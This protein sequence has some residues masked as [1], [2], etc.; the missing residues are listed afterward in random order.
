MAYLVFARKY[1]PLSFD[2]VVGQKHVTDTLRRAIERDRVAHAYIFTGTRG[3]GKT[4]TA[5]ILARALN[6]EKGPTP[7]PCGECDSCRQIIAG[8]NF[9]V[10]EIDGASNNSVE[11]VRELRDNIGYTSMT[12]RYRVFVIDE[13]HMLSKSAFNALLK[14][15]E[16]PPPRVVFILATTE[17]HKIPATIHSRC[18]RH[19]FRRI[20][21]EQI[22][23]RLEFIC[24][25]EGV[26]FDPDGLAIVARKADGSM[27]DGLSL[28]DQVYS[29]CEGRME[30]EQVRTVLGVVGS[31]SY[32]R[33]LQAVL[34]RQVEPVLDVVRDTLARGYD[35]HEFVVGLE[36]YLR[37]LI[38]ALI[39]GSAGAAAGHE[40]A[41]LREMAG[42]F[43]EHSL[44]RMAEAVRR[45][46]YEVSQ[47]AF[48][49][50][51]V[52]TLLLKLVYM[53]DTVSL[54]R[55]LG[56]VGGGALPTPAG[57]PKKKDL[58]AERVPTPAPA[59]PP[60]E[61]PEDRDPATFEDSPAGPA[62][63]LRA[64][65]KTFLEEFHAERPSLSAFLAHAQ[66]AAYTGSSLDLRFA[67]GFRFPFD[68]LVR[69]ANRALIE[70]RMAQFA[71]A[72]V[73]L[74]L[75]LEASPDS[76]AE[77][78]LEGH[79]HGPASASLEDDIRAEPI[80]Q[81]VLDVFDGEVIE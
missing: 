41:A 73:Q 32:A 14:T 23:Q 1:R 26:E 13:V 27:R 38:L 79:V 6:C 77:S 43:G 24:R 29:Y 51:A 54:E 74:H 58:T 61:L 25:S 48:P 50:F 16:E 20:S 8:S 22:Q 18:Q 69:P 39:P 35:L 2:D 37:D 66:I 42:R 28:L 53:E 65:W 52:E 67:P 11:D 71:G 64:E 9:D 34:D 72:P 31:E 17:P 63:D 3:V 10:V 33:V 49:R 56:M 40:Q 75:T 47:S 21:A 45:A 30:V 57:A 81:T 68:E 4:T 55:L 19:D 59:P 76:E 12:G 36:E 80:I 62:R 60:L 46:E 5:R 78:H 7:D 70:K 44:L 15:L